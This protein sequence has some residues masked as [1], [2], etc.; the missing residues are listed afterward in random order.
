MHGIGSRRWLSEEDLDVY[1][2]VSVRACVRVY[3]GGLD[4][5][6]QISNRCASKWLGRRR[7]E[8]LDNR[9]ERIIGR[10]HARLYCRNMNKT[11]L[12]INRI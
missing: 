3:D 11:G 1:M 6:P 9:V 8:Q 5:S 10:L 2:C 12:S 7:P 4:R